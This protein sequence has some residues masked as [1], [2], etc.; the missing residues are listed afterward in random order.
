M[1]QTSALLTHID[2]QNQVTTDKWLK[3]SFGKNENMFKMITVSDHRPSAEDVG[4]YV[5]QLKTDRLSDTI[6]LKKKALK[7]RKRQDN[8]VNNYTYTVDDIAKLV[9]E[10]KKRNKKASNIGM[11][12]THIAIAVQAAR[13]A[14]KEAEKRVEE[15][16][17]AQMEEEDTESADRNFAEAKKALDD[18][19]KMLEERMAEQ[20]RILKD[21]EERINRLKGS[22]KVQN[23]VK[24]N[25]RAR[26]ANQ[27]ADFLSYKEQLAKEKAEASAEP[28]FDP[29]A[30]RKV[31]PKNLWEV[32]GKQSN[33]K[34]ADAGAMEEEKKDSH[35][36]EDA[37]KD[38]IKDKQP[39]SIEAQKLDTTGQSAPISFDEDINIGDIA[40]LG[41][42]LKKPVNRTRKGI[43][44]ADYQSRKEAGTL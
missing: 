11:E 32:G 15:A 8:L 28:K 25:Q 5:S 13:D 19:T 18:A 42:G 10:K 7:L 12:K 31:K 1:Q 2:S 36:S 17:V 21:E 6:L 37:A 9:T 39:E 23:W 35:P 24:V 44:F 16:K 14:V 3:V 41:L 33:D 4:K 29:F 34:V 22:S 38:S 27:N 26:L 40:N 20:N 30:R 43:S